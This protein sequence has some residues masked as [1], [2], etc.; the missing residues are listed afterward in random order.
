MSHV[1]NLAACRWT[2]SAGI[3]IDLLPNDLTLLHLA[4]ALGWTQLINALINWR[5]VYTRRYL[6]LS[7]VGVR[8]NAVSM[9]VCLQA[10][11]RNVADFC[12]YLNSC[13]V[14]CV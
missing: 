1:E 9:S 4:A 3:D 6:A 11:R 13:V 2:Y 10:C 7:L 12:G 14:H 5:S 8:S